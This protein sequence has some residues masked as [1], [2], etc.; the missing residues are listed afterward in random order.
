MT[1]PQSSRCSGCGK[2]TSVCFSHCQ[3][4]FLLLVAEALLPDTMSKPFLVSAWTI[5]VDRSPVSVSLGIRIK[6]LIGPRRN[7]SH[8]IFSPKLETYKGMMA[9][10]VLRILLSQGH[11]SRDKI[12][13]VLSKN[14]YQRC[15]G[16]CLHREP[17]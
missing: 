2:T 8:K 7:I 16:Q 6:F 17:V 5:L 10:L 4:G 9:I 15:M 3:L 11:R 1:D 13:L 12:S 14:T